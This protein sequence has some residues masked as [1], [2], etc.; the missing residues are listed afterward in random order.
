M[1]FACGILLETVLATAPAT[2]A[3][4]GSAVLGE[5]C[6]EL[7]PSLEFMVHWQLLKSSGSCFTFR[8]PGW[9]ANVSGTKGDTET[10]LDFAV[11]LTDVIVTVVCDDSSVV[12]TDFAREAWSV[13]GT[14]AGDVAAEV[15]HAIEEESF[16]PTVC[17]EIML[18]LHECNTTFFWPGA[19]VNVPAVLTRLFVTLAVASVL[20]EVAETGSGLLV[21]GVDSVP[22]CADLDVSITPFVTVLVDVEVEILLLTTGA[23]GTPVLGVGL[24]INNVCVLLCC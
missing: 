8:V 5:V 19:P 15:V 12:V 21:T 14:L 6:V 13:E 24:F 7:V 10:S 4:R 9:L 16:L 3:G 17:V 22:F 2:V 23:D 20:V 11:G 1:P 18:L